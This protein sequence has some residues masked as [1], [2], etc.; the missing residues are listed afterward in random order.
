M[1]HA[2][3]LAT[4]VASIVDSH[5]SLPAAAPAPAQV[6]PRD[7]PTE[8]QRQAVLLATGLINTPPERRFD[9]ITE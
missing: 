9:A 2:L 8:T 7:F 5:A 1:R 4:V 6:D 3:G